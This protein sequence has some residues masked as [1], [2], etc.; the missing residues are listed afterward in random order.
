M[1]TYDEILEKQ[2]DYLVECGIA[3]EEEIQ[4]VTYI[5]GYNPDTMKDILYVRTGYRDFD[6]LEDEEDFYGKDEE[7]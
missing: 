4:L 3:T 6:Q 5:N 2:Y 1:L 7:E